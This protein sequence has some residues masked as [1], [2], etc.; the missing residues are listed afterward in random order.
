[1]NNKNNTRELTL[2]PEECQSFSTHI[3]SP[4]S[5][6]DDDDHLVDSDDHLVEEELDQ[7]LCDS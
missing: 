6:L 4:Q 2:F 7:D 3:T 5:P 1:M